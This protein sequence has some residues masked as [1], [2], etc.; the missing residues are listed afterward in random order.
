MKKIHKVA[1]KLKDGTVKTVPIG[2]QHKD[3]NGGHGRRGFVTTSGDFVNRKQGAKIATKAGQT[4]VK[5]KNLHST[6]LKK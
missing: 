2:K 1:I 4:K 3:I 5:T 6:E